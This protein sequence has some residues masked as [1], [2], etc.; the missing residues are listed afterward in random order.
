MY[1]ITAPK[2]QQTLKQ[3]YQTGSE[4]AHEWLT[5]VQQSLDIWRVAVEILLQSN[6]EDSAQFFASNCLYW[7]LTKSWTECPSEQVDSLREFLLVHCGLAAP[8]PMHTKL[9]QFRLCQGV[10]VY[11]LQTM[12]DIWAQPIADLIS[13]GTQS[14]EKMAILLQILTGIPE[15]FRKLAAPVERRSVVRTE[16]RKSVDVI[17]KFVSQI[18]QQI[19][20]VSV[21][22]NAVL[23]VT[24]WLEFESNI[25]DWQSTILLCFQHAENDDL[26]EAVE[27]LFLQLV[28]DSSLSQYQSFL[29]EVIQFSATKLRQRWARAIAETDL[30]L[31]SSV[32]KMLATLGENHTKYFLN[33]LQSAPIQSIIQTLLDA[34]V[35]EGKFPIDEVCSDIPGQFWS[36]LIEEVQR[37]EKP[38]SEEKIL[39]L[40]PIYRHLYQHLLR[41]CADRRNSKLINPA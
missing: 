17:G 7:K 10:A 16:L 25:D 6:Y 29:T 4:P 5:Q 41:K 2:L 39:S 26:A 24:A 15:E 22:E 28:A 8:S 3:F 34:S 14:A 40:R 20:D 30:D 33:N 1:E 31:M 19:T 36:S 23:C 12:P 21:L 32:A 35:C 11:I 9:V 18:L 38:E 27:K 13:L 37:C